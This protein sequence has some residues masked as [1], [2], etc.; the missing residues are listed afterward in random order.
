MSHKPDVL[1]LLGDDH[2]E[3][4][5]LFDAYEAT[6]DPARGRALGEQ[7]VDWTLQHVTA[8]ERHLHP[9]VARSVPGGEAIVAQWPRRRAALETAVRD[10]GAADPEGPEFDRA[11]RALMEWILGHIADE[12]ARVF[13]PLREALTHRERFDLGSGAEQARRRALDPGT[14]VLERV[15]AW[16]TSGA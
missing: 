6:R 8:V 13:P 3:A 16:L 14:G 5:R 15:R 12:E 1:E 11:V 9:A 4:E 10:M 2:R 7:L